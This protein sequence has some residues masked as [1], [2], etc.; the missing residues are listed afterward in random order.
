MA[1]LNAVHKGSRNRRARTLVQAHARS[2]TAL[3]AA[4]IAALSE[5]ASVTEACRLSGLPR[6]TA[7]DWRHADAGFAQA[8]DEAL[9]LGTDALEDE[10]VR[11]AA[12]GFERPVFQGGRQV[13]VT[14]EY[15]DTMLMMLLKARR[16]EKYRERTSVEHS[17][18]LTLEQLVL[19]SMGPLKRD[20]DPE[21][22]RT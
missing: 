5:V 21:S 9:E 8:W 20:D 12:H 15:S 10:A 3:Q 14:R 18:G 1:A 11:R 13:G 17:G 16:P 22:P 19:A 7:Y 2:R 4:F 6:Q